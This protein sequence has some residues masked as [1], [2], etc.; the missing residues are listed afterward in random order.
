[1]ARAWFGC[2]KVADTSAFLERVIDPNFLRDVW[3]P[4]L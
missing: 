3:L 2:N 4:G 1:M